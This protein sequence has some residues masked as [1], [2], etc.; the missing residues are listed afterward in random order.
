MSCSSERNA[1]DETG[2]EGKDGAMRRRRETCRPIM[3]SDMLSRIFAQSKSMQT[4]PVRPASSGTCQED[5]GR[6]NNGMNVVLGSFHG[7]LT[8][9]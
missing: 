2:S 1:A 9:C 8:C 5:T 4:V 3:K 7:T 6:I